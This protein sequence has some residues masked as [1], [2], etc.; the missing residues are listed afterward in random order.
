MPS[1]SP[2]SYKP[3]E[4]LQLVEMKQRNQLEIIKCKKAGGA[5]NIDCPSCRRVTAVPSRAFKEEVE[6]EKIGIVPTDKSLRL[7]G[8][9][10]ILIVALIAPPIVFIAG[11]ILSG[12]SFGPIILAVTFLGVGW[13]IALAMFL[14]VVSSVLCFWYLARKLRIWLVPCN[15]CEQQ[16]CIMISSGN[17]YV[18]RKKPE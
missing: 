9:I 17:A 6:R 5:F 14:Y 13:A 11:W 12:G 15:N 4:I 7:E 10:F 2:E 18:L 3:D 8:W 1:I 16:I